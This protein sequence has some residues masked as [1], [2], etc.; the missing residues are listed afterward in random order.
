MEALDVTCRTVQS[1]LS[2][3]IDREVPPSELQQIRAHL[4]GCDNCRR[5]EMELRSL[6]ALLN[7]VSA[8]EPSPDFEARLMQGIHQPYRPIRPNYVVMIGG[9]VLMFAGVAAASMFVA[10]Q[11]ASAPE[12]YRASVSIGRN[13][14]SD[15]QRDQVYEA[16]TDGPLY[17]APLVT[18]ADYAR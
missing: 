4:V 8:P 15:V 18:T 10:L 17:G 14:T 3:F 1:N 2:A 9:P 11:L 16:A 13:V 7:D 5:E 12:R 6:K